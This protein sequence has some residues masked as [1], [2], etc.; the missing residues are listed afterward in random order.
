MNHR[1]M[2]RYGCLVA[3]FFNLDR[4]PKFPVDRMAPLLN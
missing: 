2:R 4:S 1:D 3:V